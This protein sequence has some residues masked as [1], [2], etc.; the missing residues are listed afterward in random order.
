MELIVAKLCGFCA[1]VSH[2]IKKAKEILE[3]SNENIYCLGEIIHN[4][5]VIKSLEDQGMI[6]VNSLDEI[7]DNS[8]VIFRAHGE[9]KEIYEKAA[10]KNLEV[11]DLTCGK[12]RI[13]HN[14]VEKAATDS[15]IIIIGKKNH[16]ETIGTFGYAK[17]NSFIIENQED[18]EEAVNSI[19]ASHLNKVYIVAQTTF[20]DDKFDLL[21]NELQSKIKKE[22]IVDKTICDATKNRQEEVK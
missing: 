13:I 9:A 12:V 2:T 18:I 3:N 19:N 17:P 8:K 4:E 15:F 7:P 20:N 1:G 21:V 14:K 10:S 11:I 22:L 5:S 6:T 16:P